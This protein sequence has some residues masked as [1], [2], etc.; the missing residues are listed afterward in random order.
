VNGLQ[1]KRSLF[2]RL[3]GKPSAG[4]KEATMMKMLNGHVP[5]FTDFGSNAYD[6]DIVRS[7]VD[8][9]ARNTAKLKGKHIRRVNGRVQNAQSNLDYLLSV[10]PNEWMDAYTCWYRVATQ[11][12]MKN[13]AFIFVDTDS[14]GNIVGFYPLNFSQVEFVETQKEV[15]CRFRFMGGEL[16]TV[17]YSQ[18]LHLRRFFYR[19]DLFGE[20]NE[21]AILP[22]LELINTTNEGLIN[23]IK[24]SAFLRGLL[25]FQSMLKKDDMIAQRDA[26]VKD[27]LDITN[28]GGIAATDAKADY[29]ELKNDPKMVDPEHMKFI[30]DKVYKYY[31]VSEAIVKSDYTEDQW[32]SFYSSVIEPFALQLSLEMTSKLFTARE[33]GFGNEIVFSASRLLYASNETK[34]TISK[35]LLPLGIFTINEIREVWEAEPVEGGDIR[36]QTLNVVN[37][38]KADQYQLGEKPQPNGGDS[39]DASDELSQTGRGQDSQPSE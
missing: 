31:G 11:Y 9:I 8:A 6:S 19:N 3:F 2:T 17:P 15:Y 36:V 26:F 21:N 10:R 32:N 38:D 37:A 12:F 14:L 29:I 28:N 20:P 30:Q 24:S 1:E 34:I 39:D 18:V 35:E 22:T 5:V 7:A 27:Y 16:L 4:P 25:K 33:R 23:A 13:N